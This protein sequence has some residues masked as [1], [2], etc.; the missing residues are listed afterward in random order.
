MARRN[1]KTNNA[2][3]TP[4]TTP[5]RKATLGPK[6]KKWLECLH[7]EDENAIGRQIDALLWDLRSWS[8][9][10]DARRWAPQDEN[11]NPMVCGMM[12]GLLD[13]CFATTQLV[14]VR[15]LCDGSYSIENPRRGV[16]SLVSL[17]KDMKENA[18]LLTRRAM[19]RAEGLRYDLKS[20]E[21]DR[22]RVLRARQ[23]G[24]EEGTAMPSSSSPVELLHTAEQR[25][26]QVDLLA[27][28][29]NTERSGN[30]QVR[31]ELFEA[32]RSRLEATSADARD[33][34]NKYLAHAA[35][36]KIRPNSLTSSP[37]PK[38]F[39]T[40]A[41]VIKETFDFISE[42]VLGE[43]YVFFGVELVDN[44]EHIDCPLVRTE[45]VPRVQSVWDK[46]KD[47]FP[48]SCRDWGQ[49]VNDL[50]LQT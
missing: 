8:T 11:G 34:V 30:D 42:V 3:R 41:S 35:P 47:R 13:R 14:A 7:G 28:V 19:F 2:P 16:W 45:D 36:P 25:H 27:G 37:T 18:H 4:R 40:A 21:R 48:S 46:T 17:L 31:P 1:S 32:L 39:F 38:A 24:P 44:L 33:R 10:N 29:A 6:R 5:S 22:E 26:K 49:F 43:G 50:S 15:R 9:I 20:L 12:H 23:F